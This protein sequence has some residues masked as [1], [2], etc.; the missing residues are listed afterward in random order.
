[1]RQ[2]K[3]DPITVLEGKIVDVPSLAP[4][5]KENEILQ[6]SAAIGGEGKSHGAGQ[7]CVD[8]V[9]LFRGNLPPLY[10]VI[11][12]VNGEQQPTGFQVDKNEHH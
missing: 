3:I 5:D 7:T 12:D 6:Q 8:G 11:M 1:M 9:Y 2:I 10:R 4:Q